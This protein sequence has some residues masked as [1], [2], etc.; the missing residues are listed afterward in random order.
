MN[1]YISGNPQLSN[2][3]GFG[4]AVTISSQDAFP[5]DYPS[6]PTSFI[7]WVVP[8]N[9]KLSRVNTF[10]K[11]SIPTII[12]EDLDIY[13]AVH[14]AKEFDDALSLIW[15]GVVDSYSTNIS[16]G[17][18]KQVT[19]N[20]DV[21]IEANSHLYFSFFAHRPN[22]GGNQNLVEFYTSSSITLV[23]VDGLI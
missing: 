4:S 6:V 1:T 18:F 5:A 2:F 15:F 13:V 19:F 8:F 7:G 11:F 12:T 20:P 10:I 16:V 21:D 14:R 9:C 23:S 22:E 3:L 17:D